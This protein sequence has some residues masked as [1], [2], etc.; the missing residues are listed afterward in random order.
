M[1]T[2]PREP[3]PHAAE[4]TRALLG[5]RPAEESLMRATAQLERVI[6]EA[7]C[8]EPWL[9]EVRSAIQACALAVE[10]HFVGL[11]VRGGTREQIERHEPRLIAQ[12]EC[13]DA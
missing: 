7:P 4:E 1:T 13:L 10:Y 12:L 5:G 2:A 6:A 9:A 3:S 11:G 8:M